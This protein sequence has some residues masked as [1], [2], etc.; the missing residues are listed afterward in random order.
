MK[1]NLAVLYDQNIKEYNK[2]QVYEILTKKKRRLDFWTK[3]QIVEARF[4]RFGSLQEKAQLPSFKY[5]GHE[6]QV[7]ERTVNSVINRYKKLNGK[8]YPN[9]MNYKNKQL[10][11]TTFT[12][13]DA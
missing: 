11:S 4:E 10:T 8:L 7:K 13:L 1:Y 12:K 9:P 2:S 5:I 3:K 6:L